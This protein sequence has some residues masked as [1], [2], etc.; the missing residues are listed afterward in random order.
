MKVAAARVRD[1]RLWSIVYSFGS[2]LVLQKELGD[3]WITTAAD[4]AADAVILTLLYLCTP[5]LRFPFRSSNIPPG[6][7]VP[8]AAA[9]STGVYI[10]SRHIG[11]GRRRRRR[12]SPDSTFVLGCLAT[13]E[14]LAHCV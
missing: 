13:R 14:Q 6:A 2:T 4:A 8:R 7:V 9:C 1:V 11:H 10:H 5:S 12:K 3:G